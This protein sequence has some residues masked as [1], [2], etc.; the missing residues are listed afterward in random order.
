MAALHRQREQIANELVELNQQITARQDCAVR[1]AAEA[2]QLREQA[3]RAAGVAQE[4]RQT[5]EQVDAALERV[6]QGCYGVSVLSGRAI[7]F[8]RLELLPWAG[9]CADEQVS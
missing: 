5:L 8:A 6:R 2:A 1:D 4:Y 3:Q 7:P 9:T